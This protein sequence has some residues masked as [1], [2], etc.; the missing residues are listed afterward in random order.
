[1]SGLTLSECVLLTE[2]ALRPS[3]DLKM[4]TAAQRTSRRVMWLFYKQFD[5]RMSRVLPLYIAI[6]MRDTSKRK[7]LRQALQRG[8]Q[9]PG[10][11]VQPHVLPEKSV[12][13]AAAAKDRAWPNP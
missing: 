10:A 5:S 12:T 4:I 3:L 1:M 9:V 13:W 8:A 7:C 11:F 6:R 2:A